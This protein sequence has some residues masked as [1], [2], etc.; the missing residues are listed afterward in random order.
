MTFIIMSV[1]ACNIGSL[2]SFLAEKG[3]QPLVLFCLKR[4]KVGT[5]P[6]VLSI[7]REHSLAVLAP[8]GNL[9]KSRVIAPRKSSLDYTKV[10]V[11]FSPQNNLNYLY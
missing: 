11:R 10:L 2:F 3:H 1:L 5:E 7:S 8:R 4:F 9:F 6:S